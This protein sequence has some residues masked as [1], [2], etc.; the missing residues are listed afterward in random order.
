VGEQNDL[1]NKEENLKKTT[2]NTTLYRNQTKKL[3]VVENK[4]AI[5]YISWGKM[6][7]LHGE[8]E[9]ACMGKERKRAGNGITRESAA[10]KWRNMVSGT[11]WGCHASSSV[12][13][14]AF[15]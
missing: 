14:R 2:T 8:R 15:Q 6:A 12:L 11:E 1:Q 13:S 10:S 5:T 7:C 9:L 3:E 4:P